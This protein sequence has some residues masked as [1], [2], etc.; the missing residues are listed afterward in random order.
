[1]CRPAKSAECRRQCSFAF[2]EPKVWI[3][4]R[5]S[6]VTAACQGT[7][8]GGDWRRV[9]LDSLERHP[10]PLWRHSAILAPDINAITYSLTCLTLS[11]DV[12][13]H[14]YHH[15]YLRQGG[16]FTRCLLLDEISRNS[17]HFEFVCRIVCMFMPYTLQ[18]K[19][20]SHLTLHTGRHRSGV[21]LFKFWKPSASERQSRYFPN[22]SST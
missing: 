14:H 10:A 2:D 11:I 18:F 4:L 3:S 9:C 1:M 5:D 8:L 22:D 15:H 16:C 21:E 20:N 13:H 17:G 12:Q 19:S 7:R 6:C